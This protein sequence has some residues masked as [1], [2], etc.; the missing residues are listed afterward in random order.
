VHRGGHQV[1][2]TVL[3]NHKYNLQPGT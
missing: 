1:T 3:K 2:N